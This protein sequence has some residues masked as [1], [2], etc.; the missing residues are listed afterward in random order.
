MTNRIDRLAARGLVER[1]PDPADRRGV[2]VRLTPAGQAA[3]DDSL[4]DL[5]QQETEIL[6][7]LDA[8]ERDQLAALL[9]IVVSP[10]D[11]EDSQAP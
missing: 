8:D 6:G 7:G 5:L 1:G 2:L 3:V 11:A 4:A 9:R 10:F